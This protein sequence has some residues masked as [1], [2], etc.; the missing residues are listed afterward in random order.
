MAGYRIPQLVDLPAEALASADEL[1]V[2]DV[3]ADLTKR[4]AAGPALSGLLGP[5]APTGYVLASDGVRAA[6]A[7]PEAL[8][9]TAQRAE[10]VALG[11]QTTFQTPEPYIVGYLGVYQNGLRLSEQ[12]FTADDGINVVLDTPADAGDILLL[13]GFVGSTTARIVTVGIYFSVNGGGV[14]VTPGFKG[15]LPIPFACTITGWTLVA[16]GVGSLEVDIRRT[17]FDDFPPVEGDSITGSAP[18]TLDSEDKA[19]SDV[20]TGWSE[21]L[22]AGDILRMVVVSASGVLSATLMLKAVV[23]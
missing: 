21:D 4:I 6:W 23:S 8:Q 9:V 1:L 3:S 15:D 17:S 7:P 11:G 13:E 20:L 10:H 14:P 18:P 19:K 16:S 2:F 22:N 5:I 12:E